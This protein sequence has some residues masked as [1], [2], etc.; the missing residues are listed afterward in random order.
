MEKIAIIS[1]V[2]NTEK[3]V[4]EMIESVLSQTYKFFELI[5]VD[6]ASS[7]GSLRICQEV[8][9]KDLRITILPLKQNIG[10]GRARN[11]AIDYVQKKGFSYLTFLDSDD[12]IEKHFLERLYFAL[13]DSSCNIAVSSYSHGDFYDS[14]DILLI[15]PSDLYKYRKEYSFFPSNCATSKLYKTSVFD[16]V[17]F[18]E[19]KHEDIFLIP[20]LILQEQKIV[21]SKTKLYFYR[22]REGSI[23]FNDNTFKPNNLDRLEAL[24][25]NFEFVVKNKIDAF[26]HF[27]N[28]YFEYINLLIRRTKKQYKTTYE[29]L[30]KKKKKMLVS[31]KNKIFQDMGKHHYYRFLL[32]EK[33]FLYKIICRI[34][35]N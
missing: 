23:S 26:Y 10:L 5:I 29:S 7:D 18:N 25:S 8:A 32:T 20:K 16:G 34:I 6:D 22:V 13:K 11:F 33:S 17:R 4:L 1:T 19:K 27:S 2:F 3:Y 28:E 30:K 12:Y 21:L 15:N 14:K 24:E 35:R 31:Y 9:K